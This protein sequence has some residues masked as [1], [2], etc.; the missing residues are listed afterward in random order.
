MGFLWCCFQAFKVGSFPGF[1]LPEDVP[2]SLSLFSFILLMPR[3]TV[4]KKAYFGM[5]L[6][7][8][9]E[10]SSLHKEPSSAL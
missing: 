2:V 7:A 1:L 6:L 3:E 8:P 4:S 10:A 9:C 5:S